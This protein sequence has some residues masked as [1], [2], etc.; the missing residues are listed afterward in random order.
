ME[1]KPV[2]IL[3]DIITEFNER[4]A[5]WQQQ[6]SMGANFGFRYRKQ[7]GLKEI[8]ANEVVQVAEDRPKDEG[9]PRVRAAG[10]RFSGDF[11][12]AVSEFTKSDAREP[13]Q[14]VPGVDPTSSG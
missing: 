8:V 10:E 4:F 3:G 13:S 14:A 6:Y 5:D 11:E 12:G 1:I 9:D 7:D 2:D